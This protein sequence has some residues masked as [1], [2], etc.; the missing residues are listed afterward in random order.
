MKIFLTGGT[1]FIGSHFINQAQNEGHT[2]ICLKRKNSKTRIPLNNQPI[3]LEG[4]L[5]TNFDKSVFEGIDVFVHLAAHSANVP[6]DTLENCIYWNVNA[7]LRIFDIAREVGISNYLVAG[8]CFEYGRSGERYENIPPDAPLEPTMTYPTSKAM[9]STMLHGWT[10]VNNVKLKYL[11]IF[12]VFGEGEAETRFYPSLKKAAL[13]GKDFPM[14]KGE[15][16][17][18]FNNV[19]DV[20]K[21][22]LME[23]DFSDV[24][25][26]NPIFKNIGSGKPQ[27]VKVFANYWWKQWDAKGKLLFGVLDYRQNEVMRFVPVICNE[28][29]CNE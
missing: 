6:Y 26:G 1:G 3:W 28:T 18:D 11:R 17:R 2:L 24:K 8:S 16:I 7:S 10:A 21:N 27:S 25:C 29:D 12:Q 23:L 15:Q 4:D 22:F 14:T 9:L 13:E 5:D 20:V 19:E